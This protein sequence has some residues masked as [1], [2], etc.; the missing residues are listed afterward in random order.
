MLYKE[1]YSCIKKSVFDFYSNHY[2]TLIMENLKIDLTTNKL[3]I[4]RLKFT[5]ILRL[6]VT[7]ISEFL[8]K[9]CEYGPRTLIRDRD[10]AIAMQALGLSESGSLHDLQDMRR[11][12]FKF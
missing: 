3:K 12:T 4:L 6:K 11:I 9:F 8:M 1:V 2:Q 5:I 7:K 10:V